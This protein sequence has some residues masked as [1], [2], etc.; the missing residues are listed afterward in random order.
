[1][2]DVL[3]AVRSIPLIIEIMDQSL[4]KGQTSE[5][6]KGNLT[7]ILGDIRKLIGKLEAY[8]S[9]LKS[10]L[11]EFYN[12]PLYPHPSIF[13]RPK[14]LVLLERSNNRLFGI[15]RDIRKTYQIISRRVRGR[16]LAP[17][18][19]VSA[20]SIQFL[21]AQGSPAIVL[22][23]ESESHPLPLKPDRHGM[24]VSKEIDSDCFNMEKN[25]SLCNQIQMD[26]LDC[27]YRL[28][29]ILNLP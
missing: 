10:T 6:Q 12:D 27:Q 24:N 26:L 14:A 29:S 21:I 18:E 4:R 25:L 15:S 22:V 28:D 1:V 20:R 11:D 2:E 5:K 7:A 3:N 17:L 16:H 8:I 13:L 9:E 19:A 23:K